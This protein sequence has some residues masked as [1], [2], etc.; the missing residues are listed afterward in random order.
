MSESRINQA[1]QSL[2]TAARSIA[3]WYSILGVVVTS[4][5]LANF[6]FSLF[7]VTPAG[8]IEHLLETYRLIVHATLNLLASFINVSVP[9]W[10][11]DLLFIYAI[12]GSTTVR[13]QIS[14][15]GGYSSGSVRG[16]C[17][18]L[19]HG[20]PADSYYG[21]YQAVRGRPVRN[22]IIACQEFGP[23]WLAAAVDFLVWP[24]RVR[25]WFRRPIARENDYNFRT[26]YFTAA[27]VS[28]KDFLFDRRWIYAAQLFAVF[29]AFTAILVVNAFLSLP[30][31][32]IA[33]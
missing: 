4:I 15:Y 24:R 11:A 29:V 10:A 2:R 22:L 18:V 25:L 13:T 12:L 5:S 26:Q 20:K 21:T 17:H 19:W 1:S 33:G 9:G 28:T 6:T 27:Q 16:L 32:S 30:T 3:A 8:I 7:A 23:V 14:A 31:E